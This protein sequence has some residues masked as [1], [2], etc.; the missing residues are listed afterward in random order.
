MNAGADKIIQAGISITLTPTYS[1]DVINWL[2]SPASGL[3]CTNCITPIATPGGT[4]T[5]TLKIQNN[6]GCSAEDQVTIVVTCDNENI[7]IPNT[8]SPNGDGVNDVFFPRG[9]GINMIRGMKIFN[10]WG[11]LV[12]ERSNFYA[13]DP[14]SGWDGL[15]GGKQ[16]PS[17]V[18]IFVIDVICNNGKVITKKGNVTLLK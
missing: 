15:V 11:Q 2:W 6:G 12:F 18:Y 3:S 4:T 5:Y 9:R 14:A 1:N 17:D 7:F 13:N 8:F 10:R 16:V